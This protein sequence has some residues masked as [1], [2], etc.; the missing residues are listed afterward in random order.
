MLTWNVRRDDGQGDWPA[1]LAGLLAALR[2]QAPDLV[3]LQEATPHQLADVCAALPEY[4]CVRGIE[5]PRGESNPIL[6]R[7]DAY[8]LLD[9][10]GL[11][12]SSTPEIP[13][14]SWDAKH[15]RIATWVRVARLADG[16]E[17]T[18]VN[19]HFDAESAIFRAKAARLLRRRFPGAVLMGD[20]NDEPGSRA[21]TILMEG[22][23]DVAPERG[24]ETMRGESGPPDAR[25]DWILVPDHVV[26]GDAR[27]VAAPP[28]HPPASDHDALA[29]EVRPRRA[30][31]PLED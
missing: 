5:T 4:A 20:F 13:S 22:L 6:L 16:Q 7:R 25:L 30:D 18:V 2:E 8:R 12:L 28:G 23:R 3:G 10:G 9:G 1:R 17:L 29:A 11:W 19:T 26:A 27:V 31:E 14:K 15:T 21:H 24:L